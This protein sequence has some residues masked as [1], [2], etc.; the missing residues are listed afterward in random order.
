M[1]KLLEPVL[2]FNFVVLIK[3]FCFLPVVVRVVAAVFSSAGL[4]AIVFVNTSG[5]DDEVL[6]EGAATLFWLD[7]DDFK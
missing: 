7:E 6:T 5:A 4:F 3:L 2:L 1:Y